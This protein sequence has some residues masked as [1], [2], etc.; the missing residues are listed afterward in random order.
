LNPVLP[1]DIPEHWGF[2]EAGL[3]EVI[4]RTG[5]KW[6]PVHVLEALNTDR[7]R[8]FISD[9]GFFVLQ[10]GREDWTASPVVHVWAMWFKPGLAKARER[11]LKDWVREITRGKA[12]MS[13][14]RMGWGRMLGPEWEIERVIWRLKT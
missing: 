8:L 1:Q 7:A 2:V 5:E 9:D 12:R 3:K 10:A 11:E 6:T 13:S 14:P 4:R